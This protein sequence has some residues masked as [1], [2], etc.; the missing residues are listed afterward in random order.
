MKEVNVWGWKTSGKEKIVMPV[1]T[2]FWDI[3]VIQWK[4]LLSE[5][6]VDNNLAI[7][8][9]EESKPSISSGPSSESSATSNPE[10]AN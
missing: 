4:N 6:S 7:C 1:A 8:A 5:G 2:Q 9:T 10:I 3:K